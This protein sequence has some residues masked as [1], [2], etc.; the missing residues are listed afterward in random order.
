MSVPTA[1]STVTDGSN[2]IEGN[3]LA[4]AGTGIGIGA[5]LLVVRKGWRV[6][7]GFIH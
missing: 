6:L 4:V 5:T 1:V 3:M 7:T 2:G